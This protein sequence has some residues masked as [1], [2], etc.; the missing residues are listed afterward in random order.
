MAKSLLNS[1]LEKATLR[2]AVE[3]ISTNIEISSYFKN[4]NESLNL[5]EILYGGNKNEFNSARGIPSTTLSSVQ[6]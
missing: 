5:Y 1:F 3:S 4:S 2:G 6:Q